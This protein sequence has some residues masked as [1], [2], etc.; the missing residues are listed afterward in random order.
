MEAELCEKSEG[1]QAT[2]DARRATA[3][4]RVQ[5]LLA[6]HAYKI[7]QLQKKTLRNVLMSNPAKKDAQWKHPQ[8][9]FERQ[10]DLLT[11][12]EGDF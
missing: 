4:V 11:V 1:V 3:G 2:A 12:E 9:F 8:S 5:K 7:V 10:Y 6:Q